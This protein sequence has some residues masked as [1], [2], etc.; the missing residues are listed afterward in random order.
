VET[1]NKEAESQHNGAGPIVD[2]DIKR[3]GEVIMGLADKETLE[4]LLTLLKLDGD[5]IEGI[6]TN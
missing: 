2:E 3:L 6:K 5:R 4:S 1:A